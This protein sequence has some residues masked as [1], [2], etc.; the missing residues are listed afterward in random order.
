MLVAPLS[1]RMPGVCRHLEAALEHMFPRQMAQQREA[2]A[3]EAAALAAAADLAVA[4]GAAASPNLS[5]RGALLGIPCC[6]WPLSEP[7]K[8]GGCG[9]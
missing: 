8:P 1:R 2:A 5:S 3:A 7:P 9:F 4:S 6:A